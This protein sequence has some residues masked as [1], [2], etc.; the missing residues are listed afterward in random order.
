MSLIRKQTIAGLT[1]GITFT[2][3]RSFTRQQVEQFADMTRDYNPIHFDERFVA[4]KGFRSKICHGLLVGS[5]VT[6]VGGQI[7]WLASGIDFRFKK[8]VFIGD[9]ITCTVTIED[10]DEKGRASAEAVIVNQDGDIVMTARLKG[11]IPGKPEIE[12]L[13]KMVYE[14]DPTNRLNDRIGK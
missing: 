12:V 13:R 7:G 8:P 11:I 2:V 1:P 4:T 10:I 14:G 3:T 5:M 6:E 9:V